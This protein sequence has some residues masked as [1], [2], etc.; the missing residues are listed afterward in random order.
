ML[1][2]T[3]AAAAQVRKLLEKEGPEKALRVFVSPGGCSGMQYGMTLDDQ[4]QEGDQRIETDGVRLVV[5]E[6]SATYL[7]GAE[8]DYT[9]ALMGGG[10]SIQNPNA[11]RSCACGHSFDTGKDAG[12]AR[13]CH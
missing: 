8:I 3:P 6:M 12:T 4:E 7:A 10:F 2:L 5:D 1:T 9:N 11:A 13:A